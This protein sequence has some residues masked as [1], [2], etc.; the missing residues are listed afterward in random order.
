MD[1]II[2]VVLL[3]FLLLEA[4]YFLSNKPDPFVCEVWVSEYTHNYKIRT[5]Q[6]A[7]N[8]MPSKKKNGDNIVKVKGINYRMDKQIT[9]PEN[10][11]VIIE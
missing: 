2:I 3:L 5:I 11:T 7:I 4:L 1:K 10:V 6:D 9:I 8:L